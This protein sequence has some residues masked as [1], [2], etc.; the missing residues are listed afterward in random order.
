MLATSPALAADT[1]NDA[2]QVLRDGIQQYQQGQYDQARKTLRSVDPN[3]LPAEQRVRLTRLLQGID[4]QTAHQADPAA[5][6]KQADEAQKLGEL[7]EAASLY[8]QV[9][10]DDTA[11]KYAKQAANA[12]LDEVANTPRMNQ[13]QVKQL[14]DEATADTLAGRYADAGR[15]VAAVNQVR[16]QLGWFDADRLHR[17]QQVLTS[18]APDAA[19]GTYTLAQADDSQVNQQ[20]I[21]TVDGPA[22]QGATS[23]SQAQPKPRKSSKRG[24][25]LLGQMRGLALQEKIAA[26]QAAARRGEHALAAQY[27]QQALEIDPESTVAKEGL[28]AANASAQMVDAPRG[29]VGQQIESIKL[30]NQATK[31]EFNELYNRAQRLMDQRNYPAAREAIQQAKIIIDRSKR[32]LPGSEYTDMR[33]KAVELSAQIDEQER[34]F[35]DEKA[36]AIEAKREADAERNRVESMEETERQVR[37]LLDR[38]LELRKE[39]KYE[40]ALELINQAL[41]LDP[42]NFYAAHIKEMIED[43]M[44]YVESKKLLRERDLLFRKH[45][46]GN[47][48]SSLPYAELMTFPADW[49]EITYRRQLG[50]AEAAGDV[51]ANRRVEDKLRDPVPINFENISLANVIDYLRNTTGLNFHVNWTA[52]QNIGVERDFPINLQLTNVPASQ[53]MD[54]ILQEASAGNELDPLGWAVHEGLVR[55][56]TERELKR[57]TV[58]TRIFDIRDLLVQVP[59]FDEA[60]EFDLSSVVGSGS[61]GRSGGSGTGGTGGGRSTGG[62]GGGGSL[63]GDTDTD[64]DDEDDEEEQELLQEDIMNLIRSIGRPEEWAFYG[65]DISSVNFLNGNLIVRTTPTNQREVVSLLTQL[66]ET[67]AMQINIEARFLIVDQSFLE[68]IGIDLDMRFNDTGS[69]FSPISVIQDSISFTDAVSGLTPAGLSGVS[70]TASVDILNGMDLA[71]GQGTGVGSMQ[72]GVSYLDDIEVAVMIRATQQ[73]RRT[74]QV[75]APRLTFFNGQEAYI[76]VADQRAFV[77]DLTP[78]PD[79]AGFDPTIDVFQTGI[80]LSVQGTISADRRFVTLTIEPTLATSPGFDEFDA[81]FATGEGTDTDTTDTDTTTTN[82]LQVGQIRIPRIQLTTLATT[83]S[84]PDK[85]TLLLGG[86]RLVGEVEVEAGVPVLSKVPYLNRFFTNRAKAKDERTL[87]ILVKP[88]I[89]IQTE[90]ENIQFPGLV[91]DPATYN[92][93]RTDPR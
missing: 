49:P 72:L 25:D 9:A 6:L 44:L 65:G 28:T 90:E 11:G 1:G 92:V 43:S 50:L 8:R 38:A 26:A 78:V 40:R 83:V 18:R 82:T 56:S 4:K 85:G 79:S 80:S 45:S 20:Y 87:I 22:E 88:T 93:G 68:D 13:A 5:K 3:D 51:E 47:L 30:Q 7:D 58:T 35:E 61:G 67:R 17:V 12:G 24:G 2:R 76:T 84:V 57:T 63:F 70:P 52:L 71:A 73:H 27:Y 64:D 60:P 36:E 33:G 23:A 34:K 69:N 39:Q 42:Q 46:V 29:P 62:G 59:D 77:S 54:L 55:I 41:F 48:E 19:A 75:T 86:Q 74:V 21:T 14:I 91:D 16:D 15:K 10:Q 32:F 66:R 31:A 81:V 53:A 89:I 37:R